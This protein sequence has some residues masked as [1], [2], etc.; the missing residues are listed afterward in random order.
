MAKT[1]PPANPLITGVTYFLTCVW[2]LG[3]IY[4]VFVHFLQHFYKI[5]NGAIDRYTNF[6]NNTW[7]F[8][9]RNFENQNS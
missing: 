5:F 9:K 7:K 4:F 1:T 8:A 2:S 6:T 3:L